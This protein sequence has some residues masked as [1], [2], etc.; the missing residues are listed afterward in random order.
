[1]NCDP[2]TERQVTIGVLAEFVDYDPQ[3]GRMLWKERAS[4][5]F[6]PA[7]NRSREAV[8]KCW[9]VKYAGAPAFVSPCVNGYLSG[10]IFRKS[11]Y[12]HRVVWALY[13][14][15]WPNYIDHI[16]RNRLNN[17]I[18]NLRS[19]NHSE[20]AK[21]KNIPSNNTSGHKGVHWSHKDE[22]WIATIA[23]DGTRHY[24]GQH[25]LKSA[26]V[27]ARI[28]AERALGFTVD[29]DYIDGPREGETFPAWFAR[30]SKPE[31]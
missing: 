10:R 19:V 14:G 29:P 28:T 17:H 4:H 3:T 23:A 22:R 6:K 24:L 1:M 12:A 2:I 15:E 5:W 8:C 27:T 21:N 31:R 7:S 9:N 16:D 26:A 30:M 25:K 13:Y 11:F 20:N 18:S